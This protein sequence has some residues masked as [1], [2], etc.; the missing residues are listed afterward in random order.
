M[1]RMAT[2]AAVFCLATAPIVFAED[3]KE[4]AKPKG[5]DFTEKG[6]VSRKD[7]SNE[8]FPNA[9]FEKVECVSTNFIDCNLKGANFKDADLRGAFFNRANLS[10]ADLRGAD[11]EGAVFNA[12]NL[13]GANLEGQKFKT[14]TF[15]YLDLRGANLK[16][17]SAYGNIYMCSFVDA[18]L[19]GADL[20][21][22]KDG[23]KKSKF[24]GAK[25]DKDT[26]WPE[27]IDPKE[28][29]AVLV[30]ESKNK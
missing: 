6:V 16:N 10:E 23:N 19:C 11:L 25:Y 4:G 15:M 22:I 1:I 13:R 26:I 9:N 18:D 27:D 14:P 12:T 8:S 30:T 2:I 20:S 7:F 28:V 29:G 21:K 5:K 24:T 17:T 3:K